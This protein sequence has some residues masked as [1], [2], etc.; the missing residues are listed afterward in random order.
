MRGVEAVK[1]L[2]ALALLLTLL[3]SPAWS[4]NDKAGHAFAG[5]SI[6]WFGTPQEGVQPALLMGLVK[7]ISDS[8]NGGTVEVEDVLA[9][10]GGGLVVY[11]LRT[12]LG[13]E[14]RW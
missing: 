4:L 7:E 12:Q 13:W 1:K 5:A 6:A 9:T 14:L 2:I 10:V 11:F 3:A 8:T